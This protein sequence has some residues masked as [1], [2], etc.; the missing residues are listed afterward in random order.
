MCWNVKSFLVYV[1][2]KIIQKY[3]QAEVTT[4]YNSLE[5]KAEFIFTMPIQS[6]QSH[7]ILIWGWLVD[8]IPHSPN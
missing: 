4:D 7:R 3:F 2:I 8:P 1:E 6:Q 5:T